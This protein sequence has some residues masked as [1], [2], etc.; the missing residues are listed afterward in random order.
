MATD[1]L[2]I[3]LVVG[4][5]VIYAFAWNLLAELRVGTLVKVYPVPVIRADKHRAAEHAA[6]LCDRRP[7]RGRRDPARGGG[8]VATPEPGAMTEVAFASARR[9]SAGDTFSQR[10]F[11][12]HRG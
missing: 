12:G 2:G 4:Q 1:A 3:P 11:A 10:V 7:H 6:N 8:G 5:R 9:C